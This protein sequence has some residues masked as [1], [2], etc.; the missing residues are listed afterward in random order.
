MAQQFSNGGK[1]D[2]SVTISNRDSHQYAI[3]NK[4]G[5]GKHC[6]SKYKAEKRHKRNILYKR[7]LNTGYGSL[8]H[9][10]VWERVKEFVD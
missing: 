5:E 3:V 6:V 1:Y 10:M 7:L 9:R 8:P 2:G 4:P